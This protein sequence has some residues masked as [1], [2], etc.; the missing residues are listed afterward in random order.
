MA[1]QTL[2]LQHANCK[3]N[4]ESNASVTPHTENLKALND[5]LNALCELRDNLGHL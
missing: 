4:S 5:T 3:T 2:S 1:K